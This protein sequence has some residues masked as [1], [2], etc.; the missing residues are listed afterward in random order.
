[1][2]AALCLLLAWGRG[3]HFH[4]LLAQGPGDRAA[5][6]AITG[7]A[8]LLGVVAF[9]A[10]TAM[11]SAVLGFPRLI[12]TRRALTRRSLFQT[13]AAEWNSLS[14]FHVERLNSRT[15]SATADIIGPNASPRLLR[16]KARL[17]K[18]ADTYRTPV[19]LIVAEIHGRQTEAVGGPAPLPRAASAPIIPEYG[20]AGFRMPWATLGLIAL[21]VAAFVAEHRQGV[22]PEATPLKP[23][24]LTLYAFG[25][26][27][28]GAVL[29][30]GE[31]LRL[32]SPALLHLS[33]A[34][35][36]GNVAALL[37]A[38]WPVERLVGRPWFL[39]IFLVGSLAGSAVGLAVYPANTTFVGASA[40]V[41]GL[42]GAMVVL[43]FRLPT[44]RKRTFVAA[45]T[46][47]VAIVMLISPGTQGNVSIGHAAHLGGA[48][49]G[50]ALGFLLLRTWTES[51]RLPGFRRI[52]LVV[53]TGGLALALLGIPTSLRL[54]Q[55]FVASAQICHGLQQG[56]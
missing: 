2:V 51:C 6:I 44:L 24:V 34:H 8:L 50:A 35:L 25:G 13:T 23:D 30:H 29:N 54:G 56:D 38:G 53:G 3:R 15:V 12:V 37:L 39:A 46:T 4:H 45:R 40:G 31:L 26:L 10:V 1:M 43:S 7:N 5:R 55:E 48:L 17:F 42:F 28:R 27:S 36:I 49:A 22:A 32:F 18:I 21:L 16:G 20:V 11:M 14:R 41:A 19:E 9:I 52:G 47:L 33:A